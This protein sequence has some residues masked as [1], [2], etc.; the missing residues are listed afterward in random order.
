MAPRLPQLAIATG[1]LCAPCWLH[2]Q[3]PVGE[4]YSTIA[5]IRGS[6]TL[7]GGGTTV[8]SGSSI[9][10]GTQPARLELHR[11][12][13]LIVCQ[14]TTV[15]VSASASGRDLMF[16]FGSGSLESHYTIG[17]SSDSIIT[18]DF[19]FVVTGPGEFDLDIGISPQ[20][21]TC[22][23]SHRESTG[24]VIVNEQMGDG[25]YQI[26][27]SDFVVFHKGH[28]AN[29]QANPQNATCGCPPAPEPVRQAEVAKAE[30]AP[31]AQPQPTPAPPPPV[32]SANEH[33]VAETPFV[34]NAD[35]MPPPIT[36]H[37][38]KLRV[39]SNNAFADLHPEVQ[40]PPRMA[41]PEKKGFWHKV[42][43]LFQ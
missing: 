12:G 30:P 5:R 9:E 39:E 8:L 27:P 21:D 33:V 41:K 37:V 11:G 20:G 24:G 34:F 7:A 40:P 15:S 35:G 26:K 36:A 22:M 31:A 1:L 4:L 6:V 18:P 38:M 3:A 14:G 43:S 16:S 32:A 28:I 10:S 13:N 29:A 17:A 23:R 19:R 2:A 25:T 42:K